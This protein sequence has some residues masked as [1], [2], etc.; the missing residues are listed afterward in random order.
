MDAGFAALGLVQGALDD[1]AGGRHSLF[2]VVAVLVVALNVAAVWGLD[3]RELDEELPERTGAW[4]AV[5]EVAAIG[6][7]RRF[8]VFTLV[9]TVFLFL[10]QAVLEPFGGEVLGLSVRATAGFN[11]VQTIGVP[12][13]CW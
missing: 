2:A 7:A 8:F 1:L 13:A 10:Q 9:A 4:G 6:A 3:P 12:S 11:A 5:K